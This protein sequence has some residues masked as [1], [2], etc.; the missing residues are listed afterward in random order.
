MRRVAAPPPAY[1]SL[2]VRLQAGSDELRHLYVRA[3]QLER[4]RSESEETEE[5]AARSLFV[6]A[7]PARCANASPRSRQPTHPPSLSP[8]YGLSGL[9]TLLSCFGSVVSCTE[10]RLASLPVP[11]ALVVFATRRGVLRA[12]EAASEGVEPLEPPPE[13]SCEAAGL[14]QWVAEYRALRP[15]LWPLQAQ[16]DAWAAADEAA[17]AG[18]RAES[19]AAAAADEDGWTVVGGTKKGRAGKARDE[20]GTVVGGV[21]PARAASHSVA[22]GK[23]EIHPDFYRHQRKE[24]QREAVAQLRTRFTK[25]QERIAALRRE[26]AF[27]PY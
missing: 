21:A 27:R 26:R 25:D 19:E 17:E 24:A 7:V 15:G 3:H 4:T 14:A 5:A 23:T 16:L 1:Q 10:V 22:K 9:R 18:A 8:S 12:L 6:A 11:A 13:E 2:A 20:R